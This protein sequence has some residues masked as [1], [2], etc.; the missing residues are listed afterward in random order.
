MMRRRRWRRRRGKR[1]MRRMRMR[2]MRM[3]RVRR[4]RGRR[5]RRRT[6]INPTYC[7]LKNVFLDVMPCG[8]IEIYRRF[9]RTAASYSETSVKYVPQYTVSHPRRQQR[10]ANVVRTQYSCY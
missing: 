2:R 3:R 4:R 9:R 10:L 6:Q 5:S 8:L 7:V 1:R